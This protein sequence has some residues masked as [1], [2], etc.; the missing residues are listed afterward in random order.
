MSLT[1]VP[2]FDSS[3]TS[4]ADAKG[5][6]AA[7]N[8]AISF[9]EQ[10]FTNVNN[11]VVDL[12]FSFNSSSSLGGAVGENYSSYLQYTYGQVYNAIQTVDGAPSATATQQQAAATLASQLGPADPTG[13]GNFWLTTADARALG[14]APA[15]SAPPSDAT[16][17][18]NS[19]YSYTWS[20][21]G[22]IA[23]NTFDAVGT[24]EHEISEALGRTAFLGQNIFRDGADYNILDL[25]HYGAAGQLAEPF[26][27]GYSAYVNGGSAYFSL[28]G[29][30]TKGLTFS[31]YSEVRAGNDVA[32][33][34][35]T[36]SGDSFGYATPGMVDAVSPTDMQV[37]NV[38]GYAET[39]PACYGAGT[40]IAT[41]RGLVAVEDLKIGDLLLTASGKLRPLKWIGT[42]AY[43]ARFARN[44]PDLL[45]IRFKACSLAAGSPA[46]DLLVSPKH[47]MFLDGV[48]ISAE[49][50]VNGATIVKEAPGEDIH[51]F[52]LELDSHDVLI[53]EG[54][55]SESFVDDDSRAMFQNA[56][57]FGA[58]YPDEKPREAIY[59]APRVEDGFVLD[60]VRR[61]LAERAG[62][63][64]PAATDFGALLGAIETCDHEGVSGWALSTAF[65]KAPVCLDVIVDGAFMAYAY[66]GSTRNKGGWRFDL[67]F[68]AALDPARAHRVELRRSADGAR[69]GRLDLPEAPA[70]ARAG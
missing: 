26:A 32:D 45:P 53:A 30:V 35:S 59:C 5:Y 22:G 2:T 29:G 58:L 24:L 49:L 1:I 61:R 39:S 55:F 67:R 70:A 57:E 21:S 47:A 6:E 69:L 62:L 40:R 7:V 23:A 51:Y 9:F 42:R 3:V 41:G 25:Y 16:V 11:V 33:W 15:S 65:R 66:A 8:T 18:L 13:N 52:H 31:S 19:G 28:D 37:L 43:S 50:L 44:N 20:Q 64:Y 54:A 12:T 68:P 27:A 63:A 38:L 56:H 46:R 14:L 34:G 60:R 36:V 10:H 4:S 17:T 48:L